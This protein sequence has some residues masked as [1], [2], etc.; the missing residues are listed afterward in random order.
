[1]HSLF[2]S[3]QNSLQDLGYF[4]ML[5]I[6]FLFVMSLIAVN[7]FGGKLVF[8]GVRARNHFDTFGWSLVRASRAHLPS[9][10]TT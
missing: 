3:I 2:R 5:V 7:L 6:L 10:V 8:R 9:I 1:M 4:G